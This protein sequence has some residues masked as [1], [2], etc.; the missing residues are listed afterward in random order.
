ML[1]RLDAL[2]GLLLEGMEHPDVITQL[3]RVDHPEGITPKRQ[4][5]LEYP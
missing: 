5:N 1:G 3:D 4:R 2:G